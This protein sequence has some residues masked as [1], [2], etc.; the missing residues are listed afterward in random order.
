MKADHV[1]VITQIYAMVQDLVTAATAS[2]TA[3]QRGWINERLNSLG[4]TT[5]TGAVPGTRPT[6][7]VVAEWRTQVLEPASPNGLGLVF[8]TP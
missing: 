8:A 1:A 6:T 4:Y 3:S 7:L 2:F 5:T